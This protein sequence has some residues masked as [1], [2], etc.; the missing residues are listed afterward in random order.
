MDQALAPAAPP[1]RGWPFYVKVGALSLALIV[2]GFVGWTGLRLWNAWRSIDRIEFALDDA[3]IALPPPSLAPED[4]ADPVWDPPDDAFTTYLLVGS[5]ETDKKAVPSADSI[6]LFIEPRDDRRSILVSLPRDL[7]VTSPCSGEP[8]RLAV[9]LAGCDGVRGPELLALAIEGYSNLEIDHFAVF[10]FEG[11]IRVVDELGGIELCVEHDFRIVRSFGP[12]LRAGCQ[13]AD[14]ESALAWMRSRTPQELIDGVWVAVEGGDAARL[15][16]QQDF[17]LAVLAKLREFRSIDQLTDL[18]GDLA[19]TFAIDEGLSLLDAVSRAWDLRS[20]S[21]SA[22]VRPRIRV[23]PGVTESGS[24]AA[25]PVRTF[26]EELIAVF[27][28]AAA[29][30]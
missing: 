4:P 26:A 24:Y 19:N 7:L 13:V 22:I 11:F 29:Y 20:L 18:A 27:P 2:V 30:Y 6:L 8:A 17:M 3:R 16:R 23:T 21:P 14:G 28:P 1:G 25:I 12:V 15:E 10:Q 5:D 9:N